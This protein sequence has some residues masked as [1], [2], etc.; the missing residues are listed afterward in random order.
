[1]ARRYH[2]LILWL[3]VLPQARFAA[4]FSGSK[5]EYMNSKQTNFIGVGFFT[6][7]KRFDA[8]VEFFLAPAFFDS[9]QNY[10]NYGPDYRFFFAAFSGYFRFLRTDKMSIFVG[11]G[12][13]PWLLRSYAYHF[14][15]GMD[16][17]L[18]EHWRVFYMFRY[19]DN[20]AQHHRYTT[21]TAVSFG[22]K[23]AFLVSGDL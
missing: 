15:A 12:I 21:G 1:M 17:F 8:E 19:M 2:W 20:N 5:F 4:E 6:S 18:S 14:A 7:D 13:M 10:E 23:Y 22:L 16:F 9:G 11:G 3:W